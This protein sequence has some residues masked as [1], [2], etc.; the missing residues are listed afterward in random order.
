MGFRHAQ[1]LRAFG[2]FT[3][4]SSGTVTFPLSGAPG[5]LSG[6]FDM[7]TAHNLTV[8]AA[9]GTITVAQA[10]T[11][12]LSLNAGIQRQ[13]GSSQVLLGIHIG[14]AVI[15]ELRRGATPEVGSVATV[16]VEALRT[17]A[18]G[19]V[20]SLHYSGA[21]GTDTGSFNNVHFTAEKMSGE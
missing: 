21:A 16:V 3:I 12:R 7:A 4:S 6:G 13:T 1:G 18:P 14:G 5:Q 19:A 11:Y 9:A 17:L 10:G 8:D 20:L 2:G 15:A